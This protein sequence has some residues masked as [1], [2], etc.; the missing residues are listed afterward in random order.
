MDG[1]A[2]VYDVATGRELQQIDPFPRGRGQSGAALI[3]AVSH[4]GRRLA[5][6]YPGDAGAGTVSLYDTVTWRKQFELLSIPDVEIASIAFSREDARLSVGA[7][8]GTA[9]V[10]SLTSREQLVAYDGPTASVN[11]ASF[12]PDGT[13]VLT[14][15][16]DGIVRVWRA[17]GT[18]RS[19]FPVAANVDL[20]A[21]HGD[22]LELLQNSPPDG[23]FLSWIRLPLGETFRKVT[24]LR[25]ETAGFPS[26]SADGRFLF[27]ARNAPQR[28]GASAAGPM[29][30]L[31]AATGKVV[32]RLGAALVD[33]VGAPTF[34]A[35]DSKLILEETPNAKVQPGPGG[36][37]VGIAG[38]GQ[39]AVITVG[40]GRRVTLPGAHPCGPGTGLKWA[41]SG[42][43][44]RVAQESFCGIV[45]VW[46]TGTGRLLRQVDEGGQTSAVALNHDGSRLLVSSW[47]SRATIWSVATGRRLVNFVGHTRG[48]ADAALSPDGTRVIT[49]SLDRTL[50][51]WDARTGQILRVLTFPDVPSPVVFSADGAEFALQTTTPI[52]GVPN[53]VSVFDT[54][55]ACQN[56]SALLKLAAPR[57]TTNLTQLESTVIAGS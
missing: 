21:L 43:G 17:G 52:F 10:W 23:A 24:L 34:S 56:P 35:D 5:I 8:D 46:D 36:V 25:H 20:M 22:T 54:C 55:P 32:R 40:T 3:V 38:T 4:D 37:G 1:L 41:F 51:V 19:F 49:G 26:L 2:R 12:S 11:S 15:S 29:M 6:G 47:D 39:T 13:R 18:D 7:F 48:I 28:I 27:L 30:I 14:A 45:D 57:A 53:I 9:G 16:S 50:R 31:D 33:T 44:R 42:D